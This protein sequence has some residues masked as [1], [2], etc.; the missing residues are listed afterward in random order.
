MIVKF[1]KINQ[2]F[3]LTLYAHSDLLST[4]A[5]KTQID[6][7][8]KENNHNMHMAN[9]WKSSNVADVLEMNS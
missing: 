6:L 7:I 8:I 4:K 3:L 1:L 2:I 5:R 9:N